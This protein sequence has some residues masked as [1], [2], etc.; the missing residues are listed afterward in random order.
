MKDE[1]PQLKQ[2]AE[3]VQRALVSWREGGEAA[4]LPALPFAQLEK[5]SELVCTLVDRLER[6]ETFN[7]IIDDLDAKQESLNAVVE[8][9]LDRLTREITDLKNR[10]DALDRTKPLARA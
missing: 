1:K 6:Q 4:S 5:L 3:E 9:H 7:D 8:R 10:L 2:T